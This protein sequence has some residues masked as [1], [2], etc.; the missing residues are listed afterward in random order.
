MLKDETEKKSITQKIIIK[1]VRVEIKI[2]N[3]SKG[4]NKI[5]I[6]RLN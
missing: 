6:G 4:I 3:K 2:K 5:Y 1:R